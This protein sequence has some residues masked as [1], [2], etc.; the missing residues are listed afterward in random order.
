L[1]R[2]FWRLVSI[3]RGKWWSNTRADLGEARKLLRWD[4]NPKRFCRDLEVGVEPFEIRDGLNDPLATLV[5]FIPK[6]VAQSF[7]HVEVPLPKFVNPRWDQVRAV[8]VPDHRVKTTLRKE[9]KND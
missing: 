1:T 5:D 4:F 9:K 6:F 3:Y 7:E 2:G 8:G